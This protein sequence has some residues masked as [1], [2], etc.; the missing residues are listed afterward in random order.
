MISEVF[1]LAEEEMPVPW[2]KQLEIADLMVE[3]AV[4]FMCVPMGVST[5]WVID[6]EDVAVPMATEEPSVIMASSF[7]AAVIP[8]FETWATDPLMACQVF[9][10]DVSPG[11]DERILEQENEIGSILRTRWKSL[12]ARGGG[13]RGVKT[14]FLKTALRV[15]IQMDVRDAMGANIVNTSGEILGKLLEELSGGRVLMSILSNACKDRRAG[16][17][18]S[19][20]LN[21]LRSTGGMELTPTE[22]GRRIVSASEL[23]QEDSERAVT[24][25]KGIMNGIS[26][27]ALATGNDT[28]AVEA[29]AHAWSARTGRV[30]GLST[31]QMKND[32]L[33]GEIELPLALATV[34]G[35]VRFHPVSRG[36]LRILGQPS[37]TRLAGIAAAVGLGQN[38]AA[39]L[40]LVSGGIQ[41]GHMKLHA[42]RLAY[43]AGAR[44]TEVRAV[45][46]EMAAEQTIDLK[47]ATR[48]WERRRRKQ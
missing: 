19:V 17:R 38:F 26:A 24:H 12:E 13:F 46:K 44:N 41:K 28:R 3:N 43:R 25:N 34:G 20:P 37:A 39:L 47:G 9:L 29:A 18:F 6:G 16:A 5:G 22:I 4:G 45:A 2:G 33:E 1:G 23:A 40:A 7:A 42:A 14:T 8:D 35:A 30:K 27:L 15:D 32:R 21:R 31:F 10:E 48:I 11:G 36:S